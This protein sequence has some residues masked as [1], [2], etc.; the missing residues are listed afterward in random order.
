LTAITNK[1]IW[2]DHVKSWTL[3]EIHQITPHRNYDPNKKYLESEAG[4]FYS[5]KLQRNVFYES[6]LE[7]KFYK[8]LEKSHEVIYYVE[9][10]ITITYDR[11]KYT[12]DAIVFLDDGKGFVVEIKPLTEMANQSVQK[13]FK[14]LLDFCEETGLGATLTDGRTDINHIFETIP[15]LAFEESILQSLKEFKKLTYGKVNELKNKY[16]VTT[17]HLL[18]CIIKNNLSYNSMPTLIWKTK[19]PIICDLLLSPE[20]KMLLKESTDIINNDKT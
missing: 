7:K 9:Q 20:N 12:P 14:A 2:F 18:Q 13:K 5:N 8:R 16:Q 11:G 15:N 17:I 3:E 10:G 4:E 6:M 1:I 19:K